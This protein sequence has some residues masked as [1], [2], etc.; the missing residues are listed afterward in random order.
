MG[1]ASLERWLK[2]LRCAV[3][4]A[5]DWFYPRHCYH[6]GK[7][8][9]ATRWTILCRECFGLLE[10]ARMKEPLCSR[11]GLPLPG[12]RPGPVL[13]ISCQGRVPHFDVARAFFRYAGPASSLTLSFK[14]NGEFR[15][16]PRVLRHALS[17]GW[18]PE[19]VGTDV[20]VPVPLHWRRRHQRGFNQALWLA[21]PLADHLKARLL[22]R[23]LVRTRHTAQQ[24]KLPQ[25]QRWKN[26][27]G[28]FAVKRPASVKG[29]HVLLVD[30]VM[31]TGATVSECARVLKQAGVTRVSVLTL[32]RVAP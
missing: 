28:A 8:L 17:L 25:S 21:R 26:V 12:A 27:R 18:M 3:D 24:A 31:T 15:L 10:G 5:L 23:A 29:R 16:G 6:C 32:T 22:R 2:A 30:D 14:F 1:S 20:I 13:C 19:G 7:P 9:V 4:A 11:C